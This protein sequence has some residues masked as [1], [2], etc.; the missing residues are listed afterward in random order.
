MFRDGLS[1]ISEH[2]H[3]GGTDVKILSLEKFTEEWFIHSIE[4]PSRPQS[5]KEV[6][7]VARIFWVEFG[8][9][10]L[11]RREHFFRGM[12]A[13]FAATAVAS[14]ILGKF[15]IFQQGRKRGFFDL[16]RIDQRA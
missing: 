10:A 5:F 14:A 8:N 16:G 12:G 9:P 15:E 4:A 3:G 2:S 7:F 11:D 13:E 6:V 1:V